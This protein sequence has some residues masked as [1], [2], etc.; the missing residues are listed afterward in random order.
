MKCG[1]IVLMLCS[2]FGEEIKTFEHCVNDLLGRMCLQE[3]CMPLH[4]QLK[5]TLYI[6]KLEK[7]LSYILKLLVSVLKVLQFDY[8]F[9][10]C[11]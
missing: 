5:I 1:M 4:M 2:E 11:M 10:S 3:P 7:S 6:V 8:I 9:L